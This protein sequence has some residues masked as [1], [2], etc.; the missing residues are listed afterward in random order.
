MVNCEY[1]AG[2][3]SERLDNIKDYDTGRKSKFHMVDFVNNNNIYDILHNYGTENKNNICNKKVGK[4][5]NKYNPNNMQYAGLPSFIQNSEN[6]KSKRIK[7]DI[8]GH[9]DNMKNVIQYNK[10]DDNNIDNSKYFFS[11][12]GYTL[13]PKRILTRH[14][15]DNEINKYFYTKYD[16]TDKSSGRTEIMV[17]RKN[18]CSN[19]IVQNFTEFDAYA[20]YKK[21]GS[22]KNR[23][24]SVVHTKMGL[25]A[26]DDKHINHK[27]SKAQSV[28]TNANRKDNIA[29]EKYWLCP[30]NESKR[31]KTKRVYN[32]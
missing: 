31:N 4:Y 28:F 21:R 5:D 6:E 26:K 27:V 20:T 11:D 12:K 30:I 9:N 3:A 13:T 29:P 24:E 14:V 10:I 1:A 32:M 23:S 22:K 16:V 17:A 7:C 18:G 19:V 25:M 15:N 8:N 2:V